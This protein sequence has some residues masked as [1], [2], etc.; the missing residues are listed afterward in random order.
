M[1]TTTELGPEP[2]AERSVSDPEPQP[3]EVDDEL[4]IRPRRDLRM[5]LPMVSEQT[6]VIAVIAVVAVLFVVLLVVTW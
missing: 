2:S 4:V 1:A 3:V 5:R 6:M